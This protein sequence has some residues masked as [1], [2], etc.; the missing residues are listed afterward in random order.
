MA[1]YLRSLNAA[2]HQAVIHDPK[3][4]LQILAGP[5]SGKTRVL[6]CRVAHLV[7]HHRIAPNRLCAVTFTNK[8]ANEM[9]KRLNTLIGEKKTQM[10]VMGTFHAICARYLRKYGAVIRVKNNFSICDADESKKIIT[11]LLKDHVAYIKKKD[12]KVEPRDVMTAISKAKAKG[13]D[14][15]ALAA[16]AE[17]GTGEKGAGDEFKRVVAMIFKDY[18]AELRRTNSLDFDDLLVY[19]VKLFTAAP[20]VL[21]DCR[22]I[23]V[24][25]FQDTNTMQYELMLCFARGH[26]CISIVGDPDQSI[27]GWRSAE[28]ENIAKMCRDFPGTQQIYL[29]E[30]YR[31]TGSILAISLAIVSQDKAR[32]NKGLH[33]SHGSGPTPSLIGVT[34]EIGE[35]AFIAREIKRLKAYSGGM[36]K[37]GDFAILLRFNAL[38]RAI[39][40]ALQQESIPNR[41]LAGHKYFD[42]REV[43]DIIAY[44]Q[45]I[46]N[47]D[48]DSAFVRAINVPKRSIGA[49][50]VLEIQTAASASGISPMQFVEKIYAGTAPDIKPPI[51]RK[52]ATFVKPIQ[53]L[54]KLAY[55]GCPVQ[56]IIQSL[57][58]KISYETHL[59]SEEEWE[60]RWDNVQELINFAAETANVAAQSSDESLPNLTLRR[61]VDD[62]ENAKDRKREGKG[63]GK[64]KEQGQMVTRVIAVDSDEE[65]EEVIEFTEETPLRIFLQAATLSTDTE[66]Q[67]QDE[68][69]GKVTIST[70]HAA[71]G[72]EWPVVFIPAV[73]AGTFP[74]W[75]SDDI[76]EERR[77]L[78]V[79]CT[80]AQA[81]LYLTYCRA[82]MTA[83][84]MGSKMLS[85][86]IHR[87]LN[88]NKALLGLQPP[89]IKDKER[90]FLAQ[91]LNRQLPNKIL[92]EAMISEC[93]QASRSRDGDDV[94]P[95][96]LSVFGAAS[97]FVTTENSQPPAYSSRSNPV[98]PLP[99]FS[100]ARSIIQKGATSSQI[101]VATSSSFHSQ[102]PGA[103]PSRITAPS[104]SKAPSSTG[105]SSQPPSSFSSG[106]SLLYSSK[107]SSQA[108]LEPQHTQKSATSLS[109][110]QASASNS[111][112]VMKGLGPADSSALN[113]G[114][115]SAPI[116]LA[117]GT[118]R[119][120]MGHSR[121]GYQI[122]NK[123]RKPST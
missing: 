104:S 49:K 24:D 22:H 83:G 43:K 19:G 25:E 17:T 51:K 6:T 73:E 82:R 109:T 42:R 32:I 74:S 13:L 56:D 33:T 94:E 91:L 78:Y 77:L 107:P 4:P 3:C 115:A 44:L 48:F 99:T 15:V 71:K 75:R 121:T 20:D 110:F 86:F 53:D 34:N 89:S 41:M 70:C 60:S 11:R 95:M 81:L 116:K 50:S 29:E 8:A 31:S 111:L 55:Q 69:A 57:L 98:G 10:L 106:R 97:S 123:K 23:L 64:A 68:S 37:W 96:E 46:D 2:Q 59:Q 93:R 18:S 100:T 5:G 63:K 114:G 118:K 105:T 112:A 52:L 40:I 76:H 122:P 45:L 90:E 16:E 38:S 7:Q 103:G 30:N 102:T 84:E 113:K 88:K 35:A 47:P 108:D 65:D 1:E 87:A 92:I 54:R 79:A 80:R 119:L 58:E 28:V 101:S 66:I 39:E 61:P 26:K 72:L 67:E 120:G 85:D 117:A 36:L 62:E 21:R 12:M 9:R 14:A 27:Y